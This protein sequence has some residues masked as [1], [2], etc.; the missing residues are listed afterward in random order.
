MRQWAPS[1]FLNIHWDDFVHRRVLH[2]SPN[3]HFRLT[4]CET[5]AITPVCI[6]STLLLLQPTSFVAY[7]D[8][9]RLW[10][11]SHKR[12]QMQAESAY[13]ALQW[14][15]ASRLTDPAAAAAPPSRGLLLRG[16]HCRAPPPRAQSPPA[17]T[18]R[19]TALARRWRSA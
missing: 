9:R 5:C 15:V 6:S 16:T 13:P 1:L 11:H 2:S 17:R 10:T 14:Y 4:L 7:A 19:R 12:L 8:V 18:R 3:H